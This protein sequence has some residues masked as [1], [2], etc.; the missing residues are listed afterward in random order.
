[1]SSAR[2]QG[3]RKYS[4]TVSK[5]RN[6]MDLYELSVANEG[7]IFVAPNATIVGEVF[8]GSNIAVWH[9]TVIRGDMNR[10]K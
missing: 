9:G 8:M 5:A 6:I 1:M 10:V 2:L 7:Q 3:P 4:E